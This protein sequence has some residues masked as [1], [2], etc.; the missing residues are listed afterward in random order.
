MERRTQLEIEANHWVQATP[1]YAFP[2]VLSQ[3][4]APDPA[5]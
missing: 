4:G 2:F 1:A 5:R 3:P